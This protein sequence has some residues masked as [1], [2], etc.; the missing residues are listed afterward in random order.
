MTIMDKQLQDLGLNITQEIKEEITANMLASLNSQQPNQL[1]QR[2][3]SYLAK[4]GGME[5][6]ISL[7]SNMEEYKNNSQAREVYN[8]Y[9]AIE[10][11]AVIDFQRA[12]YMALAQNTVSFSDEAAKYFATTN[13]S[14]L[15]QTVTIIPTSTQFNEVQ[16]VVTDKEVKDWF[17]KNIN[18]YQ[19]KNDS[20]DIDVAIFP[21]QPSPED[22]TAIQD[23][24]MNRAERL[25]VAPSIE[26]YNIS[27][28]Y[29]QL[30]SVYYKRSD[31]NIDTLAKLIFDRPIGTV[32]E[33]F[34][35]ENA[36]WF[37]GKT[38][39][40]AMRPD[41]VHLAYL[42]VDFKSDRNSNS[43]RT[44]DEAKTTADSLKNVLQ[45][46]ANIFSLLPDYL[47]GRNAEDTTLWV[48]EHSTY[49]QLYNSL[50]N[51][52]VYV[53]DAPTAYVVYQ[54]LERAEPVEKR[55]FVIYSEEIKPSDVTVKYIRSQAMQLQ[56]ESASAQDLMDNAAK[57][58]IQ[59][60]QGKDITPMASSIQ[61]LQNAREIVSW[62]FNQ[63]TKIDDVSDV[64]NI[65][66][67]SSFVVAA[68]RD[69]KKKGKP[70]LESVR[71]AIE[72]ELTAMK[73]ME[74]VEK[75]I[76][77]ELNNGSTIQQIAEK[78]QTSFMDSVKLIFGGESYQNRGVENAAIGKI[79]TLPIGKSSVVTGKNNVYA[80]SVYELSDP[81]EP[82]PNYTMEKSSLKNAVAGRGRNDN[83]ILEGLKDKANILDQRYLYFQR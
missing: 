16:P 23:T 33:P 25:K 46:G 61:Q 44:K 65:N 10:R 36:I 17:K 24:A 50:L 15:A 22:L 9:K 39:G 45:N 21:I 48:A 66:N 51:E 1:L 63:N 82:S 32:I 79:F 37:Y 74:L 59:V 28:M 3:A 30:D 11:F 62:A 2:L 56:A 8:A 53:Q 75:T 72:T 41:S 31:I 49:S 57:N 60:M 29:G 40:K 68:V 27:M 12:R 14:M 73:K 43:L 52:K 34:E 80:V 64:Y 58:G 71:E 55:Q 67:G 83:A 78:Y 47:G 69:M 35:H 4:Q 42:I 77:E 54:V 19:I 26:D 70:Q 20:R 7:I 38:Y 6:A 5:Q 18:R 76:A 13:N 81:T